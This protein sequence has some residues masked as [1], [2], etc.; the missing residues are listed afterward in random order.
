MVR[1]SFRGKLFRRVYKLRYLKQQVMNRRRFGKARFSYKNY[2]PVLLRRNCR[3]PS[4][5]WEKRCTVCVMGMH[6]SGTKVLCEYI[7]RF[8][9]VDVEPSWQCIRSSKR[10]K[11]KIDTGTLTLGHGFKL[12]KHCVPLDAVGIPPREDGGPVIVLFT[13]RELCSWMSSLARTPYEIFPVD[14]KKRKQGDVRWMLKPIEL[15]TR[16]ES[17]HHPFADQ[18][19]KSVP[20]LWCAY[21]CGYLQGRL[22]TSLIDPCLSCML[23]RY[24]DIVTKPVKLLYKLKKMGLPTSGPILALEDPIVPGGSS[25]AEL[26]RKLNG[27]S[28]FGKFGGGMAALQLSRQLNEVCAACDSEDAALH[29]TLRKWLDYPQLPKPIK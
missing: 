20:A 2:V 27:G 18:Q 17:F 13:V 24:E 23:V 28:T 19:F 14:G 10:V 6:C 1:C 3:L 4:L 29:R 8:F 25:R 11:S 9:L 15:R 21:I 22:L 7:R 5:Q 12:W 26:K 16:S